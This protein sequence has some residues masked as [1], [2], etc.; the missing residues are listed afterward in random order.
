MSKI[1]GQCSCGHVRYQ[2]KQKPMFV[3][4]C[5]CSL[6]KQQT[7]SAFITHAFIESANFEV[8]SGSLISFEGPAGSGNPHI[9]D[10]C[11]KCSVAIIS[12]YRGQKNWGVVK[13][14]TLHEPDKFPPSVHLHTKNKVSWVE[15][16]VGVPAFE[17]GYDMEAV[18]PEEGYARLSR[19]R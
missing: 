4:A 2:L 1:T 3:H 15:L 5:H 19:V 13:V 11:A 18:W 8:T 7:G 17:E 6:C 12:Y 10:R 14:G 16:P 9:V